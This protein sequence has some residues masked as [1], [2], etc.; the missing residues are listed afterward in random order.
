MNN[1]FVK[2]I[3]S[4]EMALMIYIVN[5]VV[6][7][8]LSNKFMHSIDEIFFFFSHAYNLPFNATNLCH[9]NKQNKMSKKF[10]PKRR[11]KKVPLQ[12][13]NIT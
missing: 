2:N 8:P 10:N 12:K 3:I 13:K 5:F 7:L 1:I 6:I 9:T 4:F 11:E